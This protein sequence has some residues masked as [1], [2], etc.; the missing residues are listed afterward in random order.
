MGCGTT[1]IKMDITNRFEINNVAQLMMRQGIKLDVIINNAGIVKDRTLRNMKYEEWDEVISTNLTGIFNVTK[2]FLPLLNDDGHIINITSI[3]GIKGGFGQTNYA[4]SKAG[5][6]GFTK[7]L[8]LELASK[9]IKVNAV[10][11]GFTNTDMTESIPM[12]IRKEIERKIPLRRFAESSEIACFV[13]WLIE[14]G[15]Y[16]TGSTFTIDGGLSCV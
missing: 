3:I 14:E 4:A 6:I 7:S 5:V 2:A 11:C 13:K 12:E 9:K 16:C 15:T 8:A 10:A 1:M